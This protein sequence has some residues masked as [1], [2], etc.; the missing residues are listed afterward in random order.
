MPT[1][2]RKR[3]ALPIIVH[4]SSLGFAPLTGIARVSGGG[5]AGRPKAFRTSG[6]KAA[7]FFLKTRF[8]S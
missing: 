2:V 8:A 7:Q 5:I 4:F 6:G 3:S 1:D